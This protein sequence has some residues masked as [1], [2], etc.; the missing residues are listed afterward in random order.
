MSLCNST[1][2][3]Q[4]EDRLPPTLQRVDPGRYSHTIKEVNRIFAE[5]SPTKIAIAYVVVI[6]VMTGVVIWSA[7]TGSM[8]GYWIFLGVYFALTIPYLVYA[9]R[10]RNKVSSFL[11]VSKSR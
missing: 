7:S 1:M 5:S 11:L 9:V 2:T 10:L 8:M 6:L 3:A 4:F